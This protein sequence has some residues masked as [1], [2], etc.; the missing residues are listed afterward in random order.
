[1]APPQPEC[2]P[3]GPSRRLA[4]LQD[5]VRYRGNP[6]LAS[7]SL[8]RFYGFTAELGDRFLIKIIRILNELFVDP[9]FRMVAPPYHS[10]DEPTGN[11]SSRNDYP[12]KMPGIR[13]RLP[14]IRTH[15]RMSIAAVGHH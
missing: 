9:A 12:P 15:G 5:L 4:A 1:V 10:P 6:D 3:L 2:W 13:P 8:G 7:H 14:Q 11:R